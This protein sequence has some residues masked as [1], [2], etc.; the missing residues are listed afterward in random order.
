M[1]KSGYTDKELLEYID[2]HYDGIECE[3][4]GAVYKE[5]KKR[6][7]H[8]C[9]DCKLRKIADYERSTLVA[10]NV[11]CLST[12]LFM[13]HHTIIRCNLREGN[14]YTRDMIILRLY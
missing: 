10:Q 12:I 14:A 6:D 1:S 8:F 7:R 9:M 11:G 2:K 3:L 4:N 13:C 5:P